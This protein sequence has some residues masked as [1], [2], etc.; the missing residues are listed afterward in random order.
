LESFKL[1]MMK[2]GIVF[3]QPQEMKMNFIKTVFFFSVTLTLFSCA[4]SNKNYNPNKKYS[5]PQLQEDYS[6]LREILEK[7]HPSLYWYTSKDSMDLYFDKYYRDIKDSMTE[8]QF[9]W[10]VIAP[11]TDKIHCGHT[12]F[13]M[14]KGFNNWAAG[15]RFPS[16][17]LFMKF[18]N[19]AMVVTNNLNRKDSVLKRGMLIT[20]VNGLNNEARSEDRGVGKVCK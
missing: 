10:R 15:K 17:P 7:K 13:S 3:L 11:L 14:S 1:T 20:S 4:S 16:F 8:Q 2:S 5:A 19:D 9:G 6:L 12:S 18:W